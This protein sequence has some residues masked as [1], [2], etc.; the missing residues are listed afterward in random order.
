[1]I[2][3]ETANN[4]LPTIILL[5]GGGLSYWSFQK[6]IEQLQ[7]DFHIVTPIIDGHGEDGEETFISIEDSSAKVLNYIDAHCH[8]KVFALGGLSIGAQIVAEV[9]S[10]RMEIANYAI[11]ESALVYPI[12]GIRAMAAPTYQLFYGL[13]KQRWFSKTQA[14]TLCI[15]S[16]MFERYYQDSLN[17]SKQSLINITLSNGNYDLKSSIK[18]TKAK[19]LIIVGGKEIGIMKKSAKRLHNTIGNSELYVAPAMGHGE[20]SLAHSEKYVELIKSFFTK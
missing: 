17:I 20:I 4:G 11:I 12:K 7:T 10:Q 1:M 3:K 16:T 13:V 9:L 6:V 8:G 5:H 14:K 15:P 2:F 19:V 18:N